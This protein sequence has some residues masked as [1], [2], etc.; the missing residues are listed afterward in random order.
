MYFFTE[1]VCMAIMQKKRRQSEGKVSKH[2]LSIQ[3]L[4]HQFSLSLD[5]PS[6]YLFVAEVSTNHCDIKEIKQ[7]H[8]CFLVFVVYLWL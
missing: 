5:P 6:I 3:V 1:L 4:H 7:A 8:S 2:K